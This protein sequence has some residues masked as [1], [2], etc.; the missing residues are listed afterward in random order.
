[1]SKNSISIVM[2]AYN[3]ENYIEAALKSVHVQTVQPDELILIDD[4]S[5]DRT[6]EIAKSFHFNFECKI[7]SIKNSGQGNA[8]NIGVEQASSEYIYFF[9]ADDLLVENFIE[10]IKSLIAAGQN[11]DIALFS[12]QSF[13]D[14][15]YKGNRWLDYSRSFSGMYND[16]G[17]FLD[18]SFQSSSL[19]CSPCLY[20][21]KKDIW[22]RNDLSFGSNFLEDES[23]FYPLL[24]SCQSFLVTDQVFFLRRNRNGSTMTVKPTL[25]HVNGA[26]DCIR[27]IEALYASADITKKESWHICRRLET[28]CYAYFHIAKEAKASLDCK[29]MMKVFFKTKNLM[30]LAKLAFYIAGFD[31]VKVIARFTKLIKRIIK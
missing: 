25:K 10:D 12:G 7:I 17:E 16:R 14:D 4:G 1:M 30:F 29:I 9:D 15:K 13:N 18:K 27:S 22:S 19:F 20:I 31:R 23:I 2:P 21:S 8:R 28:Y 11:P 6:L 5:T 24:F 3:V 26:I